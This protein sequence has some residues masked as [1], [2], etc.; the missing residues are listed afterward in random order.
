MTREYGL[1]RL[2]TGDYACP[3]NDTKTL[4]R[5]TAYDDGRGGGLD[6][7]FE[8][9]RFWRVRSIARSVVFAHLDDIDHEDDLPWRDESDGHATRKAALDSIDWG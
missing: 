4:Y 6:V 3:S 9:R 1:V 5:I 7:D 8:W 2:A